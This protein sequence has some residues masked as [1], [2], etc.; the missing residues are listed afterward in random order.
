[1]TLPYPSAVLLGF[2]VQ[3]VLVAQDASKDD[4]VT[5]SRLKRQKGLVEEHLENRG[6]NLN[7]GD[8]E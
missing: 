7:I 2:K 3:P 1:M 6:R 4:K 5:A 8:D